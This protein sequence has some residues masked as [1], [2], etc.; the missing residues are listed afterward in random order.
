M[1]TK[2]I[3]I[4]DKIICIKYISFEIKTDVIYTVIGIQKGFDGKDFLHLKELNNKISYC[5][6]NFKNV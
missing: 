4:N 6:D 1:E 3:K 2:M 5:S